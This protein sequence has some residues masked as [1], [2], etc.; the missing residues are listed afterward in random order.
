MKTLIIIFTLAVIIEA[1]RDL[2]HEIQRDIKA[3]KLREERA[4]RDQNKKA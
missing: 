4:Q 1:I 3:A 2:A